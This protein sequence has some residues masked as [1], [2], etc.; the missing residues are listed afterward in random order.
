MHGMNK[1]QNERQNPTTREYHNLEPKMARVGIQ[2][3][4]VTYGALHIAT[5][6]DR[7]KATREITWGLGRIRTIATPLDRCKA[8][9]EIT[10]GHG[11]VRTIATPLDRLKAKRK[12]CG[13]KESLLHQAHLKHK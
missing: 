10:R 5:P 3:W 12:L 8:T 13:T 11:C 7:C 4:Q 6:L 9:R 1:M 2:I